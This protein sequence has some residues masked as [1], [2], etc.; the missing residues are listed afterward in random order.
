MLSDGERSPKRVE[1]HG[2]AKLGIRDG[3]Q[4]KH[5]RLRVGV[6]GRVAGDG[7]V[8]FA[9]ATL[10]GAAPAGKEGGG[11]GGAPPREPR[12]AGDVAVLERQV[13]RLHILRAATLAECAHVKKKQRRKTEQ[14]EIPELNRVPHRR[15]RRGKLEQVNIQELEDKLQQLLTLL[16]LQQVIQVLLMLLVFLLLLGQHQMEQA[17]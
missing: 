7:H 11:G 17:Q 1:N 15:I 2:L 5:A 14:L 16:I 13:A 4:K 9:R 12:Q 8:H 6:M 3:A 10:R